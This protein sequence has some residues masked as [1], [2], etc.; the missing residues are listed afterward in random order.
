VVDNLSETQICA[1]V[2]ITLRKVLYKSVSVDDVKPEDR[3]QESLDIDS[4][5]LVDLVLNL[6]DDFGIRIEDDII[7]TIKTV[8]DVVNLVRN[9]IR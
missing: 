6:E 3:L 4:A 9:K 5:R 1:R 2:K 8:G 7:E